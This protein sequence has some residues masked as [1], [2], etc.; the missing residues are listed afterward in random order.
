M[1]R[2]EPLGMPAPQQ[3]A[4]GQLIGELSASFEHLWQQNCLLARENLL[5]RGEIREDSPELVPQEPPK[6]CSLP[7]PSKVAPEAPALR[8][9]SAVLKAAAPEALPLRLEVESVWR[10][11]APA[12]AAASP[13]D[14]IGDGLPQ[15]PGQQPPLPLMEA[16]ADGHLQAVEDGGRKERE[17]YKASPSGLPGAGTSSLQE[18]FNRLDVHRMGRLYITDLERVLRGADKPFERRSLIGVVKALNDMETLGCGSANGP[19]TGGLVQS[20]RLCID[21]HAFARMMDEGTS[22]AHLGASLEDCIKRL[23]EACHQEAHEACHKTARDSEGDERCRLSDMVSSE[24]SVT[25]ESHKASWI[26]AIPATAILLHMLVAGLSADYPERVELWDI[27][28]YIFAT[29]YTIEFLV[30]LRHYGCR[31]YFLGPDWGWNGFD[32]CCLLLSWL[33]PA[34]KLAVFCFSSENRTPELGGLMLVKMARLCRLARLIRILRFEIFKDLKQMIMGVFAGLRV[35]TWAVVLLVMLIYV[36]G[37]GM[38]NLIGSEEAEFRTLLASMSTLFRCW[39]EGC[40]AYDGT[41]LSERLRATYGLGF[42]AFHILATMFVTVGLFNLIMATFI[43]N[44]V[45][46]QHM[47]HLKELGERTLSMEMKLKK[48]FIGFIGSACA[49]SIHSVAAI[50]DSRRLTRLSLPGWPAPTSQWALINEEWEVLRANDTS[51]TKSTFRQWLEEK[52][53]QRLLDE[54]DIE[55]ANT[56]DLFDVLDANMS[57]ALS[58]DEL[59]TGLMKLRGPV[60]KADIVAVRLKVRYLTRILESCL[61][62]S[63]EMETAERRTAGKTV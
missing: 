61:P 44:V 15:G 26:E 16:S 34:I 62:E 25:P 53:F 3:R 10:G 4:F 24:F 21:L 8:L 51:I 1:P 14:C 28:E 54:A 27:L 35:L 22:Y 48:L 46:R 39:T 23:Q 33:D 30:K 55:A 12:Q 6:S 43:D 32:F 60:T 17:A 29:W 37:I 40:A 9:D 18:Q 63:N 11:I 45:R 31:G 7:R 13:L 41:P 52:E 5:L 57:G 59:T 50:T 38:T 36:F 42:L 58:M 20:E 49:G 2:P 19:I 47:R 56:L